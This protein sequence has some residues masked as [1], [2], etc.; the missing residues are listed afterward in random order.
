MS[1]RMSRASAKR[2]SSRNV[3]CHFE[4]DARV[5]LACRLRRLETRK[6]FLVVAAPAGETAEAKQ[7]CRLLRRRGGGATEQIFRVVQPKLFEPDRARARP[8]PWDSRD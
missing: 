7:P 5:G 3:G 8:G 1:L 2:P 6:R 4:R